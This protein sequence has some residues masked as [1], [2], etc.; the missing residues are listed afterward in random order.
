MSLLQFSAAK[1]NIFLIRNELFYVFFSC[2]K[3]GKKKDT[4]PWF[5]PKSRVSWGR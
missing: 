5:L 4:G 3:N 2:I 1:I